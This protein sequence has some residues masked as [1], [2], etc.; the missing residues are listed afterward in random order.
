MDHYLDVA[1]DLFKGGG[2]WG[3]NGLLKPSVGI[4]VLTKTIM[5]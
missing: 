1:V 3:I 2:G 5:Y 4:E